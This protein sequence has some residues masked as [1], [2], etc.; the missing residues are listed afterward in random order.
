MFHTHKENRAFRK[1]KLFV[2]VTAL[3]LSNATKDQI[4]E[5][6]SLERTYF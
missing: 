6:A 4:T 2:I 3:D 1:K 5:I